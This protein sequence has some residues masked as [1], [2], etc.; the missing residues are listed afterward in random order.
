[1][2]EPTIIQVRRE[3]V[4]LDTSTPGTIRIALAV[5]SEFLAAS[6]RITSM[7]PTRESRL[8]PGI[9]YKVNTGLRP[10]VPTGVRP[11]EHLPWRATSE[12]WGAGTEI[13]RVEV[14]A[15]TGELVVYFTVMLAVG[16][17]SVPFWF[18]TSIGDFQVT[19]VPSDQKTPTERLIGQP[20]HLDRHIATSE[21][22]R[23]VE[24]P[25]HGMTA[26]QRAVGMPQWPDSS[27]PAR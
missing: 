1:M 11:V 22:P 9:V 10:T 21:A 12:A 23:T 26:S 25:R 17:S 20:L 24:P 3:G 15:V 19:D 27:T 7:A 5:V 2:A 14:D 6:D 18:E 13:K 4:R 8:R 16:P